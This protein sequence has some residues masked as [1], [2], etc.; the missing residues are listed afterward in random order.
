MIA[1][2]MIAASEGPADTGG[3]ARL[4]IRFS[5]AVD[6]RQPSTIAELFTVDGLFQ[7]GENSVRGRTT[8]QDFYAARLA[9]VRRRTRH[10]WANLLVQP[11]LPRRVRFQAVLTN[12]AFE[13]AVSESAWQMRI[14]NVTG[15]CEQDDDGNW[16]FAEHRYERVLATT[17]PLTDTSRPNPKP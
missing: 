7:P 2:S 13:P 5:D 17:L 8:I 10:L 11:E 16:R 3:I 12:Y 15:I 9:D 6:Q 4:L 1:G 14:G